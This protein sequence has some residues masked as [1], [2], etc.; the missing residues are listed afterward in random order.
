MILFIH[1]VL[2]HFL[3]H[4]GGVML[5]TLLNDVAAE[6]LLG[7]LNDI[8]HQLSADNHVNRFDFHF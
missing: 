6:L 3:I 8:T 4:F 2:N 5:K 1:N 7:Q